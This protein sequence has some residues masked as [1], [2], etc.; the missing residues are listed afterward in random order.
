MFINKVAH[1][2]C[3]RGLKRGLQDLKNWFGGLINMKKIY[4]ILVMALLV[5]SALPVF[6]EESSNETNKTVES[7]DSSSD[8]VV[9]PALIKNRE[10]LREHK[11]NL[12]KEIIANREE[13]IAKFR[14]MKQEQVD[15]FK[16]WRTEQ[17]ERFA[18][19]RQEQI[20]KYTALRQ[21][22]LEKFK[23]M[24]QEQLEKLSEL[25][26]AEINKLAVMTRARVKDMA[27]LTKEEIKEQ[28]KELKVV[29]VKRESLYMKR[30]ITKEKLNDARQ[31]YKDA[32]ENY[33][34][35]K[36]NFMKEKALFER[37]KG[38][39]EEKAVEAAKKFLT[40][41]GEMIINDLEKLKAKAQENDDLTEE[42]VAN[43]VADVDSQIAAVTA[44]ME[45]VA[46]AATKE[47]VKEAGQAILDAWKKAR[48][49]INLHVGK[50]VSSKVGEIIL[51]SEQLEAKLDRILAKM[52]ADGIEVADLEA[53]VESFSAKI[54]EA[55]AK[56]EEAKALFREDVKQ[57][58]VLSKEAHNLLKE[59]HAMLMSLWKEIKQA[60]G[61]VELEDE[62][63]VEVVEEVGG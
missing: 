9:V 2:G 31:K 15:K 22:Q 32:E 24:R 36:E 47:D 37:W 17:V 56:H 19:M 23:N 10:R 39:D 1:M 60:G 28:L 58:H 27:N 61:D 3:V 7:D 8:N 42:E 16:N 52:E 51:R 30:N 25:S 46:D 12:T 38:V 55:R 5:L 40:Y 35:A 11:E 18:S 34:E 29:R 13:Q 57:A 14:D 63:E 53:K 59:A 44:A 54:E 6:A 26:Q 43:I 48:N 62:V 20:E 50:M 45:E 21:E 41:A 33:T 49:R 4:A